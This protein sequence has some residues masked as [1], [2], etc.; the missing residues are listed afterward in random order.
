M[1]AKGPH[2]VT[3]PPEPTAFRL[4]G[5]HVLAICI[6]FFVVVAAVNAYMMR[7][8]VMTFSG[9]EAENPYKEGLAFNRRLA[10]A[11]RQAELGWSV[12]VALAG[13]AETGLA[14]TLDLR[15]A[16]G[17]APAG[18]AGIMRLE[19]PADR[20]DDRTAA[21]TDLGGG[22]FKAAFDP[23]PRGQWDVVIELERG[24]DTVF[25][26]RTRKILR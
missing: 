7:E 21:L 26:S 22:H 5:W 23:L 25:V 24:G 19:R 3:Q 20:R 16:D 18:V 6:A 1:I 11:R 12:D 15:G 13:T 10:A 8:A 14:A 4:T 9:L 17:L 2:T